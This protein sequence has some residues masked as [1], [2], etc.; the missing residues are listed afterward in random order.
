MALSTIEAE[1]AYEKIR[2]SN[3]NKKN[4]PER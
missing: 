3:H 4:L 2:P 1:T